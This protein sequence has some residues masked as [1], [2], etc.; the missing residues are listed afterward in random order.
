MGKIHDIA[1]FKLEKF[2]E[3]FRISTVGFLIQQYYNAVHKEY[4]DKT[5]RLTKFIAYMG[6]YEI[7]MAQY[8]QFVDLHWRDSS[9]DSIIKS[10]ET[11]KVPRTRATI[12]TYIFQHWN[13]NT[14]TEEKNSLESSVK[15]ID[16]YTAADQG[17]YMP[18][19][20]DGMF[21]IDTASHL[22]K[23]DSLES[24]IEKTL[25]NQPVQASSPSSSTPSNESFASV[26]QKSSWM[27]NA[28]KSLRNMISK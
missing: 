10:F 11:A 25:Q 18:H 22:R 7:K 24:R 20:L 9:Y 16:T 15:N 4:K 14:S 1:D 6:K 28:R 23:L 12:L 2:N 26:V 13:L 8:K 5:K 17:I 19:P 27:E 3:R 21:V